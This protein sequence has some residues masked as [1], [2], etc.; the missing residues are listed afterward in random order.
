MEARSPDF[1]EDA[2][3]TV[4]DAGNV[5]GGDGNEKTTDDLVNQETDHKFVKI[6]HSLGGS[7]NR[8][9]KRMIPKKDPLNQ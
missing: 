1:L 6:S 7:G 3:A 9:R 2:V 5:A 8:S 4:V